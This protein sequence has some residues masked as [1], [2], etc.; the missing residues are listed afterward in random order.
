[1]ALKISQDNEH[2]FE[3]ALSLK[4]L[5]LAKQI[6]LKSPSQ[7][8]WRQL[9]DLALAE[10]DFITTEEAAL[11]ANDYS[12]LYLLYTSTNNKNGLKNLVKLSIENSKYNVAF[13]TLW[14]L[15]DIK[16]CIKLLIKQNNIPQAAMLARAYYPQ[17]IDAI[18]SIWKEKL[19]K[20]SVTAANALGS[21]KTLPQFFPS[22]INENDVYQSDGD[23]DGDNDDDEKYDDND[24]E[25]DDIKQ[26]EEA[27]KEEPIKQND[28]DQQQQEEKAD[29]V[30]HEEEADDDDQDDDQEDED[31]EVQ[32]GQS[33]TPMLRTATR[34]SA[35][36]GIND[37]SDDDNSMSLPS[38]MED[39]EDGNGEH[40]LN[41]DDDDFNIDDLDEDL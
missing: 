37:L 22:P 32:R 26:Q 39:D 5:G 4:K 3:L 19:K 36:D 20:I 34:K 25:K 7:Q 12:L 11:N 33:Q 14:Y 28:D 13:N 1:M 2:R 23:G 30:P 17:Q 6:L 38:G 41:G 8:K 10:C 24:D 27:R 18:H 29:N 40:V 31:E 16:K 35:D 15:G 21:T 9:A